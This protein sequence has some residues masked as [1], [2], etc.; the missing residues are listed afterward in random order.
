MAR[1]PIRA[2]GASIDWS[3]RRTGSTFM[4]LRAGRRATTQSPRR[5]DSRHGG[6]PIDAVRGHVG[7]EPFFAKTLC[8]SNAF[9]WRHRHQSV[10]P[11]AIVGARTAA[12]HAMSIREHEVHSGLVP[13][14]DC[15]K[16]V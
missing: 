10:Y 7:C 15:M 4:R 11:A 9:V 12:M 14:L 8:D 2:W 1:P 5:L 13:R 6:S 16:R 3:T